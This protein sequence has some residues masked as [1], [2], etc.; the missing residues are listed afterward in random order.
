MLLYECGR[1]L[2]RPPSLPTARNATGER[3]VIQ[4][5]TAF[6]RVERQ[7][8]WG[9]AVCEMRTVNHRYLEVTLRLPDD[10]RALETALRDR[11]SARLSRG[12]VECQVRL[13]R[14]EAGDEPL[15]V[16][17]PLVRQL[18]AAAKALPI[19]YSAPLQPLEVLRWPGVLGRTAL[20][21]AAVTDPLLELIDATLDTLV[22]TRRREGQ[23][24]R[25]LILDRCTA[26]SAITAAARRAMPEIIRNIRERYLQRAREM[27]LQLDAE[28]LEQEILLLVQKL[29]VAEEL[30]RLEAHVAEV[31]HVLEQEQPAGRRL[32]FLMQELNREANTLGSKAGTLESSNASVDLKVLIEQI[33]EQIQNVE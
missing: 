22:D 21:L 18:L 10:L 25:T 30:D 13:D 27:D 3:I 26:I 6:G 1:N 32:D 7:L 31:R 5:M 9:A 14:Q 20:D 2:F 17:E 15:A 19:A 23:R 12:K 33:R 29:D 4:S 16:N 28:R 11:I 24:I 8:R